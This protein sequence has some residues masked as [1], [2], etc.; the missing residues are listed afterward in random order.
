MLF[1]EGGGTHLALGRAT[2]RSPPRRSGSSAPPTA[3]RLLH[4]HGHL[5]EQYDRAAD[6]NVALTAELTQAGRRP[7]PPGARLRPQPGGGG[8]PRPQRACN[9]RSPPWLSATPPAGAPGRPGCARWTGRWTATT[10]TAS[11]PPCCAATR[12]PTFPGGFIASLS[13]PW[14]ASKGDDDLGGYHL[15]WPR[16]LVETAG[17]FLACGAFE[18]VRR[19]LRYLRAVQEADGSWPQN[20]WLDGKPYWHGCSSTSAPCRS[21][22]WTSP[23]AQ[24]ALRRPQLEPYWPMVRAAAGLCGAQRPHHQPGPLGGECRLHAVHPG[25]EIAALL[26]AADLA[27]LCETGD[28]GGEMAAFLRDTADAWKAQIDDWLYVTDTPLGREAGVAGYYIRIAPP[29]AGESPVVDPWHGRSP[30]PRHLRRRHAR[31]RAGEHRRAGPGALRPARGR[32]SAHRGHA[33]G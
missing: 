31:R 28:Q 13:I 33:C 22:W 16:D 25:A 11:A 4:A 17:G 10:A 6:G 1:A 12:S 8:V 7:D 24:G 26:A 15:V 27:E 32:R 5:A 29:V 21:C 19:V 18:E 2:G 9:P 20:C 14:G 3:G 30:Q 23:G